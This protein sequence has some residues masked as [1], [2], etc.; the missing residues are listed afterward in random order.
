M[1]RPKKSDEVD[2]SRSIALLFELI[3]AV[4]VTCVILKY[5]CF[6]LH[7]CCCFLAS[8]CVILFREFLLLFIL[9]V[10]LLVLI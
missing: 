4:V 5:G 9:L 10:L 7:S 1:F 6:C 3:V 8:A 2:C